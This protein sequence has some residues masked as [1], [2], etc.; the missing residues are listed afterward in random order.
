MTIDVL[1]AL[2]G[3]EKADGFSTGGIGVVGGVGVGGFGLF[4]PMAKTSDEIINW[5]KNNKTSALLNI[6]DL[7]GNQ[8]R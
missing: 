1:V 7:K 8:A 5:N 2:Q 3:L 4:D 6:S